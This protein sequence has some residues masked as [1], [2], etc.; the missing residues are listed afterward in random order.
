[1]AIA[2]PRLNDQVVVTIM[3]SAAVE[4]YNQGHQTNF[5]FLEHGMGLESP[6]GWGSPCHCP[7]KKSQCLT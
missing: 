3:G 7:K 6:W 2:Q 5:L 1:M 4:L